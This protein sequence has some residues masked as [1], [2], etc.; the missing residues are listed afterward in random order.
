MSRNN[1]PRQKSLSTPEVLNPF[2]HKL[3][4]SLRD[5]IQIAIMSVTI[6]PIRLVLVLLLLLLAWPFAAL[7]VAF[8]SEEDKLKPITGWRLF[9]N[10]PLVYIGRAII[11]AAGFVVW[12]IKG[13]RAPPSQAPVLVAAPH[14]GI[15]DIILYFLVIPMSSPVSRNENGNI[16]IF[17][18]LTKFSQPVLV[19]REDP[20][21]RINTIKEIQRRAQ[22]GGRW[23]QII[24]FPEGTCTN[25]TCLI[26]F[27]QGAFYPGV[28]VQP[29]CVKYPNRL[30]TVTWT[31]EGPGAFSQL[32]FT[33]CQF[34]TRIEIEYLP[35]YTPSEAEKKDPKLFANNVREKMASC[36]GVP[37][38]DHT[39]DD[40]RL[41]NDAEKMKLPMNAGIVEFE[42]LHSKLG[43]SYEEVQGCLKRFRDIK[44]SK[45]KEKVAQITYD[46]FSQ[47]LYLPKSDALLEVFKLFDRDGSGTID[48]REYVIGLSLV[49]APANNDDTILLAFQLFDDDNK[50]YIT[51]SDLTHILK[52]AFLISD[53]DIDNIF[54]ELNT[55]HSGKITLDEFKNYAKKKPEYARVFMTYQELKEQNC[56]TGKEKELFS[57]GQTDFKQWHGQV[58]ESDKKLQ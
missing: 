41:M 39:Y 36:L 12:P 6:A 30:D 31:W 46:E 35:V 18:T 43:V 14:S 7:A 32:W 34:Y 17:G 22:S 15:F 40:C 24:I 54:K 10:W 27:K 5:K 28:P 11:V 20:N 33:L 57:K 3:N 44:G 38:T 37:V 42:K 55:S 56:F 48:F 1:I 58:D 16:P 21:S 23:P 26:A 53:E 45:E 47:Y 49:A 2:V 25:R 29:V 52:G 51:E 50:G 9:M 13:N 4:L 8:R 19:K